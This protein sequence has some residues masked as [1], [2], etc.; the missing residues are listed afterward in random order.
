MMLAGEWAAIRPG[1]TVQCE[2]WQLQ[3]V[4]HKFDALDPIPPEPAPKHVIAS[5]ESSPGEWDILHGAT[6]RPINDVPLA[7]HGAF[8][9]TG[10]S[11]EDRFWTV[12]KMWP[13]NTCYILGGGPSLKS[14]D[15]NRLRGSRV[16]A[17]NNAYQLADWI[18]VLF[19]GDHRWFWAHRNKFADFGGL[20]V[21]RNEGHAK[22][23]GV[24]AANYVGDPY[25]ISTDPSVLRWNRSSGACAINL[26]AHFGVKRI[27]LLGFDMRMI[28]K[29]HNWHQDHT[30]TRS[31]ALYR[32][33]MTVFPAIKADLDT[34]GIECINA[35]PGSSLTVFPVAHP[36]EVL[37][38]RGEDNGT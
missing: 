12:P 32:E 20:K 37:P 1:D 30:E 17:V 34:L 13:G 22:W 27:I 14:I 3:S 24:L 38:E 23:P 26:A 25:G 36:D 16:I 9:A 4:A 19:F 10:G 33:F 31:A 2:P 6:G 35:T 15:V 28:G 21:T 8:Q 7:E 11:D 5:R 29:R 18:D